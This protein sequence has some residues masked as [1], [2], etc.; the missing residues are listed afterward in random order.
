MQGR[1]FVVEQDQLNA[2]TLADAITKA[3]LHDQQLVDKDAGRAKPM[4][5]VRMHGGATSAQVI[6]AWAERSR[7]RPP[8]ADVPVLPIAATCSEPVAAGGSASGIAVSVST[9]A[10]AS[11]AGP[12]PSQSLPSQLADATPAGP[13]FT[14]LLLHYKRDENIRR[15]LDCLQRQSV[16]PRIFLWNN[17]GKVG[18][19]VPVL[20]HE[21][22]FVAVCFRSSPMHA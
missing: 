12:S 10:A 9:P 20:Q 13:S 18:F 4:P 8:I 21:R 17:S 19:M 14:V 1:L 2:R 7:A 3:V 15:I 6:R 5:F 11:G 16:R 22:A